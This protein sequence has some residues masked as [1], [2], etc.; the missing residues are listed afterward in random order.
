MSIRASLI[1]NNI[2][3]ELTL[4]HH[5]TESGHNN[6]LCT[7]T[8]SRQSNDVSFSLRPDYKP[9]P[10][11]KSINFVWKV[12]LIFVQIYVTSDSQNIWIHYL[13]THLYIRHVT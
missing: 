2:W 9:R 4:S 6:E 1:G 8:R 12:P 7:F 5:L 11:F 13:I 10:D 3:I